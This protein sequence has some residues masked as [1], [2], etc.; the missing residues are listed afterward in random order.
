MEKEPTKDHRHENEIHNPCADI[1][2]RHQSRA[3]LKHAVGIGMLYCMTTFMGRHCCGGGVTPVIH[4]FTQ[5][6]N[7]CCWIIVIR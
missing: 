5:I 3:Q 1:L 4:S 6:H 2:N 7:F